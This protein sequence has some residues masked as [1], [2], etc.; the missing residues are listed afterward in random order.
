MNGA[1]IAAKKILI[2]DDSPVV[3]KVLSMVLRGGGYE[4]VLAGDG[5]EATQ[6]VYNEM[7]DLVVLDIFMPRMNG[8]QVCRLLKHDPAVAHI[9]VVINTASEGR[10][11]EFWSRHTGADAFMLKGS[12]PRDLLALIASTLEGRPSH[13][14][15]APRS[16]AP[17]EILSKVSALADAELHTT[18]IAGIQLKTILGNLREGILARRGV[19]VG[20][21]AKAHV[22]DGQPAELEGLHGCR[23]LTSEWCRAAN[24]PAR[25]G[26]CNLPG[27]RTR[28]RR[29]GARDGGV[30]ANVMQRSC[31]FR[32][33]RFDQ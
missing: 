7:P 24:L 32:V 30:P 20:R 29:C 17:E 12:P 8:Y 28:A 13:P 31:A 11:A 16:P 21:R 10:S 14:A 23:P 6:A 19:A 15:V 25:P 2:A 4:V 18:T 3:S 9:P 27:G 5:I 26:G 1:A 33:E 22:R